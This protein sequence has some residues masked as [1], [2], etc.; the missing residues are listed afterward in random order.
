MKDRVKTGL[1]YKKPVFWIIC[2]SIIVCIVVG[3]YFLTSPRNNTYSVKV[4]IPAGFDYNQS[5][6]ESVIF[7]GKLYNI[8]FLMFLEESSDRFLYFN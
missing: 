3:I 8:V 4:I 1:N 5:D 2:I 6:E 7:Y